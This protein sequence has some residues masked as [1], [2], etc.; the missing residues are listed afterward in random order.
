[1]QEK[2]SSQGVSPFIS[3][4]DQLALLM[5]ADSARYVKVI[6]DANIRIE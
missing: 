4:P 1:V 5:R 2:F 3:T 6:A